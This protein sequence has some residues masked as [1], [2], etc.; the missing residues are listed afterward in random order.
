MEVAR[1]RYFTDTRFFLVVLVDFVYG[2]E[3][4]LKG[5]GGGSRLVPVRPEEVTPTP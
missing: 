3:K 5:K 1:E 4:G 2:W